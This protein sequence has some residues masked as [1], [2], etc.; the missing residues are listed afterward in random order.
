MSTPA[1]SP[2]L[3][4]NPVA[5]TPDIQNVVDSAVSKFLSNVLTVALLTIGQTE[6]PR[7][8][9]APSLSPSLLSKTLG[10]CIARRHGKE[11]GK[12]FDH[13]LSEYSHQHM[14]MFSGELH[15]KLLELDVTKDEIITEL[16]CVIADELDSLKQD[17]EALMEHIGDGFEHKLF[18]LSDVALDKAKALKSQEAELATEKKILAREQQL[19][20]VDQAI[21]DRKTQLFELEKK[22]HKEQGKLRAVREAAE[23]GERAGSAPT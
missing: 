20:A 10:D 16:R 21:L 12:F 2:R 18:M 19:L 15:E 13:I 11:L 14:E 6:S 4:Y 9:P 3:P 1:T 5:T 17:C 23:R 7:T 22:V 8:S